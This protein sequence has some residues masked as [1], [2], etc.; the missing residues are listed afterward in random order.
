MLN[1]GTTRDGSRGKDAV[2]E[3]AEGDG[4]GTLDV[5]AIVARCSDGHRE[6]SVPIPVVGAVGV[7]FAVTEKPN[8]MFA[9]LT[10][11]SPGKLET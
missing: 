3:L 1:L 5:G 2:I 4:C 9:Q 8:P 11:T 6:L 7:S 10:F